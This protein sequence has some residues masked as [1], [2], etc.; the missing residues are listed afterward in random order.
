MHFDRA[1]GNKGPTLTIGLG[2]F[3]A[4]NTLSAMTIVGNQSSPFFGQAVAALPSRR[5]QLSARLG[6]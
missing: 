5:V 2:V 6:F 4:L 3:N 1:K